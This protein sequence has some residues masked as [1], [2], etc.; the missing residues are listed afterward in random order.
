MAENDGGVAFSVTG[1]RFVNQLNSETSRIVWNPLA[2]PGAASSLEF[3]PGS[4]RGSPA[5]VL[6]PAANVKIFPEC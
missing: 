3:V 2:G 1:S 4:R 5:P 6:A